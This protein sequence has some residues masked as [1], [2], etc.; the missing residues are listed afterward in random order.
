[1]T[2][3]ALGSVADATQLAG[4]TFINWFNNGNRLAVTSSSRLTL[5]DTT[6][7]SAPIVMGTIRDDYRLASAGTPIINSAGTVAYTTGNGYFSCW[8]ITGSAPVLLGSYFFG[9]GGRHLTPLYG[10]YIYLTRSGRSIDIVDVS[11]PASPTSA[12]IPSL[13]APNDPGSFDLGGIIILG[14][15]LFINVNKTGVDV[16][17]L[18]TNPLA[19]TFVR[20]TTGTPNINIY[21]K[22]ATFDVDEVAVS[23]GPRLWRM[24]ETQVVNTTQTSQASNFG[25][26]GERYAILL[27]DGNSAFQVID[28]ETNNQVEFS[29]HTGL[30][31]GYGVAVYKNWAA[32]SSSSLNSVTIYDVSEYNTLP[33][34][35]WQ[36]G[37][38]AL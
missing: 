2:I 19:P 21:G 8:S 31:N 36:V 11:N 4:A 15:R 27:I 13:M 6:N 28:M 16:W 29:G 32:G 34:D 26:I 24:D 25:I 18:A 14:T 1:M 33:S 20:T 3:T 22:F 17:D 30:A 35:G 10:N 38:V 5:I 9:Y 12:A 7:K 37:G 23:S